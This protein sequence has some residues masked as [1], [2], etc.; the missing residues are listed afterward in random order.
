LKTIG[1][2][3]T[4]NQ[5]M[6]KNSNSRH[7]GPRTKDKLDLHGVREDEVFDLVDAF[8]MGLQGGALKRA[9]IVTGKGTGKVQKQVIDYLKKARYQWAFEKLSNGTNNTGVLVI[10]LD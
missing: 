7:D 9:K 8:I 6:A 4:D 10:F 1:E 5:C 3:T 2:K